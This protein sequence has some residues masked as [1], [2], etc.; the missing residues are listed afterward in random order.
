MS[1]VA[2]GNVH[3]YTSS[4]DSQTNVLILWNASHLSTQ[5]TGTYNLFPL[6]GLLV[7]TRS[8][9]RRLIEQLLCGAIRG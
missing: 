2:L 1:W 5:L 3:T 7:T 8:L 6:H 4:E 9:I